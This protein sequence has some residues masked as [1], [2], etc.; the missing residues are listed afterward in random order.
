[1]EYLTVLIQWIA[2]SVST[3]RRGPEF[4]A[5]QTTDRAWL[6]K[7]G[8]DPPPLTEVRHF[9]GN[10]DFSGVVFCCNI[11]CFQSG[12]AENVM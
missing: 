11:L 1:M 5:G 4:R 6:S 10:F 2:F 8:S 9:M 12:L 3:K 7:A